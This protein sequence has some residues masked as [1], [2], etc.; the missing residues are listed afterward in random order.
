M[1][2][3]ET[4]L[5]AKTAIVSTTEELAYPGYTH[6]RQARLI[7]RVGEEG[8]GGG[9]RDRREPGVRD[10]RAADRADGRLRSVST[11]S[12]STGSRMRACGACRSSRRSAPD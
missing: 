9:A 4:I 8:E 1:P 2:Q 3:I 5:K 11:A 6:I 7:H 10:G 12:P